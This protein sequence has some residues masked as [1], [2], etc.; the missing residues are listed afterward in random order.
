MKTVSLPVE[1]LTLEQV[2]QEAAQ[3]RIVFLTSGG[4]V[5]FAVAPADDGDEE[6]TALRSN[7]DFLTY[8][9]ECAERARS[10]PRKTLRQMQELY[11]Q[12]TGSSE[13]N[14]GDNP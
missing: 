4:Y 7:P 5:Q 12:P 8:L 2:L 10:R 14:D 1:G 6:I 9:T 11:G 3:G 13:T